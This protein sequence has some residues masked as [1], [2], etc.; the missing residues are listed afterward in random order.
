[1]IAQMSWEQ[2]TT[3]FRFILLYSMG[4]FACMYICAQG[5]EEAS[6]LLGQI[7]VNYH[8]EFSPGPMQEQQVLYTVDTT[9]KI[10]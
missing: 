4:T 10:C 9:P 1:M 7:I 5:P 6:D 3:V 2:P 8:V